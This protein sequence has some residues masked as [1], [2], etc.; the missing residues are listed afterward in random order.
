MA[1]ARVPT[2]RQTYTSQAL[3]YTP[4]GTDPLGTGVHCVLFSNA[5]L[6][7]VDNHSGCSYSHGTYIHTFEMV[8]KDPAVNGSCSRSLQQLRITRRSQ[9]PSPAFVVPPCAVG[10]PARWHCACTA[11]GPGTGPAPVHSRRV[12]NVATSVA[13][14]RCARTSASTQT[15]GRA[16]LNIIPQY[17]RY[18]KEQNRRINMYNVR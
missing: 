8:P 12:A 1:T 5:V 15:P 11:A 17:G 6:T 7:V 4:A 13:N 14:P 18:S 3:I 9:W 16:A 10:A 2:R